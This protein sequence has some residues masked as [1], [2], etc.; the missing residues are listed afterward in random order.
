MQALLSNYLA[1]AL[2]IWPWV[3]HGRGSGI[4]WFHNKRILGNWQ[5]LRSWQIS[6][7]LVPQIEIVSNLCDQEFV[8]DGF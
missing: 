3:A 4:R 2:K 5:F 7:L 8:G 6:K 1:A